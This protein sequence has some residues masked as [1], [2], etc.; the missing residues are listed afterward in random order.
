MKNFIRLIP[1]FVLLSACGSAGGP[2]NG[3]PGNGGPGNGGAGTVTGQALDAQGKPITGAKIWVKPVVTTGLYETRTDAGGRYEATGL[4][5]VGYRVLAWA[6]REYNGQRYCIR[7][8]HEKAEDYSPINPANGAVRNFVLKASGRIEDVELYSDMGYF[9]GSVSVMDSRHVPARNAPLEFTLTPTGPLI[10]GKP[11]KTLT[12][13]PNAEGY[14][15]D[16]PVGV[17]KVTAVS[18]EGGKRTPIKIG[19]TASSLGAEAKLEFKPSGQSCVGSYG[20]GLERAY[21]Y[22]EPSTAT[23]PPTGETQTWDGT[24]EV[25]GGNTFYVRYVFTV[26][27]GTE[28][29]SESLYKGDFFQCESPST[30]CDKLGWAQ[31]VRQGDTITLI[32]MLTEVNASFAT[33]GTFSGD[34]FFGTT[35]AVFQSQTATVN[36]TRQ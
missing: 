23:P 6:E 3:G 4:P 10:D 32:T 18:L 24:V 36:L 13:K 20:S 8:G 34:T 28:K 2:G 22:W 30:N 26:R 21:L 31:G 12:L 5:P 29:S 15:L 35:N 16:V 14:L 27:Q 19:N 33:D 11:G 17:Y 7:L 25:N 9:G 1:V